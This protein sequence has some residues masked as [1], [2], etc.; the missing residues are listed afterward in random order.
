MLTVMNHLETPTNTKLEELFNQHDGLLERHQLNE[1]GIHPRTLARW[2]ETGR[3]ERIHRGLY[4]ATDTYINHQELLEAWLAAPYSVI[5]L[6]SALQ[7]HQIGTAVAG[8]VYL[9][10]PRNHRAPKLEFPPIEVH[11]FP[12]AIFEHG[13]EQHEIGG[14]LVPIYSLEKTLA[15]L[16]R[17]QRFTGR[18]VFLEGLQHYLKRKNRNPKA[19]L[20]A[21][22]I[23]KVEEK[24]QTYVEALMNN[25]LDS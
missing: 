16:L 4:R 2:L 8:R 23:C 12:T 6:I 15:D 17:Y 18:D 3:I 5:C 14:R 1:A 10:V 7:F 21:A 9:A 24:M 11:H 19:L 20:E 25:T 13:I 22:R